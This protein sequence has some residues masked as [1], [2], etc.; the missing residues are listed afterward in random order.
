[1]LLRKLD[2]CVC[3]L[4]LLLLLLLPLLN[5][6]EALGNACLLLYC[7][8]DLTVLSASAASIKTLSIFFLLVLYCYNFKLFNKLFCLT[9][10][11][12]TIN[13]TN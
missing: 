5:C 3:P 4:L 9:S 1:M 8:D 2:V 10:P 11:T 12:K 6:F 7:C 13:V